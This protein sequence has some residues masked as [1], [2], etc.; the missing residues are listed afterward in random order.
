MTP[1]EYGA[2]RGRAMKAQPIAPES[3]AFLASRLM[4]GVPQARS[5]DDGRTEGDVPAA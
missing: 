2:A 5:K 1:A 4:S 3:A